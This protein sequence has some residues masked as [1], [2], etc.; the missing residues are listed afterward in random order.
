MLNWDNIKHISEGSSNTPLSAGINWDNVKHI[1]EVNQPPTTMTAE[2]MTIRPDIEQR[3]K[4]E[5]PSLMDAAKRLQDV[6]PM[7][8]P[9]LSQKPKLTLGSIVS[10]LKTKPL[11]T[12]VDYFKPN[13]E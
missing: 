11:S 10:G 3:L 13:K 12:A 2:G 6:L 1:S 5:S 8:K 7:P 4:A 9:E